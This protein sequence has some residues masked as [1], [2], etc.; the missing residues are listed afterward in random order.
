MMYT[1]AIATLVLLFLGSWATFTDS[2]R[3][4]RWYVPAMMILS[5]LNAL[6]FGIAARMLN[7]KERIFVLSLVLDA[8]M[9]F[10]YYLVPLLAFGVRPSTPV[11]VGTGLIVLGFLFVKVGV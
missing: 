1:F 10:A 6:I 5:L 9:V 3:Q 11:L 7:D 4:S 2:V 8:L